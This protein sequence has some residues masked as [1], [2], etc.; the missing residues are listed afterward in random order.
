MPSPTDKPR[1]DQNFVDA[2]ELVDLVLVSITARLPAPEFLRRR[3]DIDC[4]YGGFVFIVLNDIRSR[5][6]RVR[7]ARIHSRLT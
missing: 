4:V 3:S 6:T 7:L 2:A 5:T 1:S